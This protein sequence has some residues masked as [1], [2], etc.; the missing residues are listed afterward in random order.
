MSETEMPK[1]A[2]V[3]PARPAGP[4]AG[5][6]SLTEL[7]GALLTDA[8]TLVRKEIEL[9]RAELGE[10]IAKAKQAGIVLGAGAAIAAVGAFLL[11]IMLVQ[12]L[13]AWGLAP[14]LAYLIVGGALTVVGS[15]ALLGGLRRAQTVD[16]LPRETL[17]TVREDVEWL[18][19]QSPFEKR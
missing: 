9:A 2:P 7:V 16:P 17:E 11:V 18:K 6:P 4:V 12:L 1:G 5:E 13:I 15:L 3:E 14:W 10:E 19:E 8:Q